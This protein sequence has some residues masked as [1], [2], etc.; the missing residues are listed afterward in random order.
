MKLGPFP[1]GKAPPLLYARDLAKP[2][3]TFD[4]GSRVTPFD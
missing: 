1:R 4:E 2:V 3:A